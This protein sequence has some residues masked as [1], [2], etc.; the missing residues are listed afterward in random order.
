MGTNRNSTQVSVHKKSC[1]E[2]GR[3]LPAA[4]RQHKNYQYAYKMN[5]QFHTV[6]GVKLIVGNNNFVANDDDDDKTPKSYTLLN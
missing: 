1:I 6:R 3:C 2:K 5:A 4:N